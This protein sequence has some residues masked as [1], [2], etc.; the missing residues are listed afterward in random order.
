VCS[1]SLGPTHSIAPGVAE[2]FAGFT[3]VL[4]ALRGSDVAIVGAIATAFGCPFEGA[5]PEAQVLDCIGRYVDLG[6]RGVT[7]GD[8]TGMANPRQVEQLVG[9]A[10]ERFSDVELTLHFH[11]TRGMGLANVVAGLAAGV[12]RFEGCLGGLGGC[13]FAPGA[14]GNV[15][16]EDLVAMLHGMGV[17]TGVDVMA[18]FT[19]ARMLEN[20]IGHPLP[21]HAWRAEFPE[22]G[23]AAP[24]QPG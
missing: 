9:R 16:T 12:A 5:V 24:N 23:W 1:P 18:L 13:P 10:R 22:W 8:T 19:T 2:S 4:A 11:N 7:F 20:M 21:G 6:V 3:E 15:A 14:A 17:E